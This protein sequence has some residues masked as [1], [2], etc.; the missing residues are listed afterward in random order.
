VTEPRAEALRRA[1]RVPAVAETYDELRLERPRQRLRLALEAR[2]LRKALA[3][4]SRPARL[5][6]VACGTARLAPLLRE[7][8]PLTGVDASPVLLREAR[9]R[10]AGAAVWVL[11]DATA[12]PFRTG[13][14]DV[15][16]STRFLRHLDAGG[17][18]AVFEELRRVSR[19]RVV[20]D[21]LLGAGLV[22]RWK[23]LY[24]A[25]AWLDDVAPKRP[26]HATLVSE[27]EA[28]GLRY[29]RRHG[30]TPGVSQPY[31]YVAE[32]RQ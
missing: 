30:L 32:V 13:S 19:R 28:A 21:V 6:D 7:Y 16:V 9:Q 15:V 20:V 14:F 5:L 17:R 27:L 12:L 10:R 24:K 23:Q 25:R 1:Y 31:L 18:R 26:D 2:I 11:G 22:W 29:V 8:G 3:D 4:I